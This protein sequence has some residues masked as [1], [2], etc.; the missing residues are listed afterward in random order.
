MENAT[1]S[2]SPSPSSVA[3]FVAGGSDNHVPQEQNKSIISAQK[4][5]PRP[6][7]GPRGLSSDLL[8]E[9][10]EV[11]RQ[12]CKHLPCLAIEYNSPTPLYHLTTRS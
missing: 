7:L 8:D 11:I 12:E 1:V 6:P 10:R 9:I 3:S 5:D 2:R 4:P